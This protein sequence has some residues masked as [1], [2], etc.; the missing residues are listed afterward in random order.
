MHG[1]AKRW[2]A[3]SKLEENMNPETKP[4]KP[5][6][7]EHENLVFIKWNKAVTESR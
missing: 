4:A 7:M 6:N 3:G 5:K 1:T 2:T